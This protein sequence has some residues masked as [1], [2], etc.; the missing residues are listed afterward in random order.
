MRQN[1]EVTFPMIP[2][3]IMTIK[4]NG[5]LTHFLKGYLEKF[6][7]FYYEQR[8]R[9]DTHTTLGCLGKVEKF[10]NI[11][12]VKEIVDDDV[13]CS[14]YQFYVISIQ[15]YHFLDS[16]RVLLYQLDHLCLYLDFPYHLYLLF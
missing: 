13:I 4:W 5:C 2:K 11:K 16:F 1:G 14:L 6:M 9:M 15:F 10:M 8:L 3:Q 7:L 12:M